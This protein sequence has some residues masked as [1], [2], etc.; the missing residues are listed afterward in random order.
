MEI[1]KFIVLLF[2][3]LCQFAFSYRKTLTF[4][5]QAAVLRSIELHRLLEP[6]KLDS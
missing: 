1:V 5:Q 4:S 3:V 2:L 6:R